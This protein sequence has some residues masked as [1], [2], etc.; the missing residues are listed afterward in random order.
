LFADFSSAGF[1][2]Y[3]GGVTTTLT[4]LQRAAYTRDGFLVLPGL[5]PPADT[6]RL[7]AWTDEITAWPEVAGRHMVYWEAHRYEAGRR[8]RNRIEN[9][10][11]YHEG[12]RALVERGPVAQVAAALLGEPAALFKDKINFKMP[13]SGGFEPHQD[14]QAG[15]STYAPLFLTVLVSIDAATVDNG[16]LELAPG[17][18]RRGLVGAEWKPLTDA[19]M[20]GMEFAACPSRPG[21]AV[22]FDSYVPHR[23]A[24][25]ATAAPRRVLYVTYTRAS[26]GDHR[27]RYFEDKR[28]AYP[29][30][31]ERE[32]GREYVYRV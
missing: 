30:D 27:Q 28:R 2:G 22:L 24:P 11:P 10:V 8:V 12:F 5:L 31:C 25:N 21:D 6:T 19:E 23:S 14:Q 16:C 18:H 29:P 17:H 3:T 1:P 4:A 15:W 13:G 26:D 20:A 32:R 9:F 7:S